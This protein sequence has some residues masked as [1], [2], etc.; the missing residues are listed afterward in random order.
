MKVK[1]KYGI[2]TYSGTVDE[3]TFGSYRDGT[4]CI[5]RKYVIPALTE[6][7]TQKG[8]IMKNLAT[9]WAEV[10]SGYKDEMK[11]YAGRNAVNV[12]KDML[13][14]TSFSIWVR[15][16]FLFSKLD[17]GHIDLSTVTY[18]D[19]QTLGEDI[20]SIAVAVEN[21]YLASVAGADELITNM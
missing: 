11:T 4:L 12:P 15:M 9:V 6:N 19:L 7:N 2:Q 21:D 20:L 16:L 3:M 10:S 17:S 18:S 5:G 1:F 13:P 8:T 14:P